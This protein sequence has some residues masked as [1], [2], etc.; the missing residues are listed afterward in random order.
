MY[1]VGLALDYCVAWSALDARAAGFTT[2]LIP[3]ACRAIDLDGSLKRA[4]E[5]MEAAGVQFMNA[6][7]LMSL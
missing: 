1:L 5:E 3:D 7:A 4:M 6:K 2:T